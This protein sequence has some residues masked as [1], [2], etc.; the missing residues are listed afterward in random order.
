MKQQTEIDRSVLWGLGVATIAVTAS[1]AAFNPRV[2]SFR[3]FDATDFVQMMLPL[4]MVSLFIERALEVFLTSWRANRAGQLKERA[5][6]ARTKRQA[7]GP[8]HADEIT[9][10][11]H[12]SQTRRIA[13]FAGTTLGV[14]V[15]ALGIRVLE[16]FVDPAAFETLPH[17]QQRLFR[18]TDV[19]LTGAVLGGGSDALHQ[20]VQVFTN[21]FQTTAGRVKQTDTVRSG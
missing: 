21:F 14:I 12:R 20:L 17:V 10:E 13:F 3:L 7:G 2:V 15:A 18:T 6:E 11:C 1:V 4:V 5:H 9:L 16:L 19:L 8:H